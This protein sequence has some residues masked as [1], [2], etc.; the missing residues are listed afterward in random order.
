VIYYR[1]LSSL[2]LYLS[3]YKVLFFPSKSS[4][5]RSLT[6]CRHHA[7]FL[8]SCLISPHVFQTAKTSSCIVLCQLLFGLPLFHSIASTSVALSFRR[9]WL[10]QFHLHLVSCSVI[11]LFHLFVSIVHHLLFLVAISPLLFYGGI[12]LQNFAFSLH[13]SWVTCHGSHMYNR[14]DFTL[15]LKILNSVL[16]E[17]SLDF[18][19]FCSWLKVQFA[20]D[21]LFPTCFPTPSTSSK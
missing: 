16:N 20:L 12:D 4:S 13:I 1:D 15:E 2:I 6:K 14:I 5:S 3:K 18:Q 21:I 11:F 19:T 7:Q 8:L 17:I 9:V 10:I